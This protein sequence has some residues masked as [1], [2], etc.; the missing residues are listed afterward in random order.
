MRFSALTE[1]R[2]VDRRAGDQDQRGAAGG[3]RLDDV[4]GDGADEDDQAVAAA[5]HRADRGLGVVAA[6]GGQDQDRAAQL[7]GDRFVAQD[8]LGVV[9]AGQVGE[10]DAVGGVPALGELPAELAGGVV[11][12]RAAAAITR[13]RVS[14]RT[15]FES[16]MTRETVAIETPA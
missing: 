14:G 10:D 12:G 6:V 3:E 1:S 5:G 8:D 9:G 2:L 4:V 16:R 7:G 11:R 15:S 13:S